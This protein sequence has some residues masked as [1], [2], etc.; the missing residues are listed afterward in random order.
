MTARLCARVTA[1]ERRAGIKVGL[2]VLTDDEL[3]QAI[4]AT[5]RLVAAQDAGAEPDPADAALAEQTGHSIGW[6]RARRPN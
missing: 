4:E 2:A 3:L 6:C 5:R 1:A